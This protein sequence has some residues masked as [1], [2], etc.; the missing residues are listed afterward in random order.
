MKPDHDPLT[1][2]PVSNL[3]TPHGRCHHVAVSFGYFGYFTIGNFNP[4]FFAFSIASS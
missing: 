3:A 1:M 2:S 4:N